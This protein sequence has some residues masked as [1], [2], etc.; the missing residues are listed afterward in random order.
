MR[1]GGQTKGGWDAIADGDHRPPF[2]EAR[3]HVSIFG[4][5]TPQAVESFSD[6]FTWKTDQCCGALVDLDA[7]NNAALFQQFGE[8]R[9]VL[10]RLT[11]RFIVENDA[12]DKRLNARRREQ[13]LTISAAVLLCG[14]DV[15]TIQAPFDRP[16]TFI[17]SQNAFAFSNHVTSSGCESMCVHKIPPCHTWQSHMRSLPSDELIVQHVR[18]KAN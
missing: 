6:S 18:G 2:G 16:G 3:S 11:H 9:T 17:G 1:I 15:D 10:R 4:Q 13:K 7:G 14:G 12:A 5:T 8:R